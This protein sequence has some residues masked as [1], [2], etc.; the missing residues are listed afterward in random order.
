MASYRP[1]RVFAE[2]Q[3]RPVE[4]SPHKII[5]FDDNRAACEP[6]SP[7]D[8]QI[9]VTAVGEVSQPPDLCRFT[10]RVT[11][12]KDNPQD[13]K[14]S[15][16]RRL[17]YIVQTLQNHGIKEED[18]HIHKHLSR[19]DSLFVMETEVGVKFGDIKK[20]ESVSN[21]L[22]EKLDDTVT[23]SLPEF[24]HTNQSLESLRK[25][26]SL[27]AIHN[28]KQKAQEMARFVHLSV[29]RPVY[30]MEEDSQEI[31]GHTDTNSDSV[32]MTT[33]QERISNATITVR[34][35]VSASFELKPKVKKVL[36]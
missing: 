36:R 9:R 35:R 4:K 20:S 2:M 6:V 15:V 33:I 26:A 10:V 21:L 24:F 25:Q 31:E 1:V 5:Q 13:A 7:G 22:V 18:L 28:A 14:N 11:S 27:V 12:K 17:D 3:N 29:G 8:R 32:T 23:V 19:S 16:A 34:S 30:I